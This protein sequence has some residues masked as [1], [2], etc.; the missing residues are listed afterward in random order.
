VTILSSIEFL[1]TTPEKNKKTCLQDFL[2]FC[3]VLKHDNYEICHTNSAVNTV[4]AGLLP[5]IGKTYAVKM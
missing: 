2:I 5:V 3:F 4:D 1:F